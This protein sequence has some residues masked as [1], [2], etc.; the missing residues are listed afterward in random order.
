[1]SQQQRQ[2]QQRPQLH[3]TAQLQQLQQAHQ[4]LLLRRPLMALPCSSCTAPTQVKHIIF[5]A[6]LLLADFMHLAQCIGRCSSP[7]QAKRSRACCTSCSAKPTPLR[8]T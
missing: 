7:R 2:Q 5:R 8:F 3:R 6:V 1:M 4:L